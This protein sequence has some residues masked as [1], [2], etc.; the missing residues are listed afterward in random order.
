MRAYYIALVRVGICKF[1]GYTIA[2]IFLF[3]YNG[4]FGDITRRW[5]TLIQTWSM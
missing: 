3:I 2:F 5:R 4:L 1:E